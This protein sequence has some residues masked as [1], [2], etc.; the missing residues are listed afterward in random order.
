MIIP[1]GSIVRA[2]WRALLEAKR[3]VPML[4]VSSSLVVA[5]HHFGGGQGTVVL[6]TVMCL[7]FGLVAPVSWRVLFP[8]GLDLGHGGVRLGLYAAVGAAF[9]LAFCGVIPRLLHLPESLLTQASSQVVSLAL[10]LVGGWGLGHDIDR[11]ARLAQAE[12][13]AAELALAAERAELLALR[14][15]LDPHFLFN[16]L[17]A[18]A[19]WCR[20]DGVVAEKAVLQLSGMLRTLLEGARAAR[21]PLERELELA[22]TVCELHRLRD[23]ERLRYTVVGA[24]HAAGIEVPPLL[25]LPLVDN[26]WKHG[27]GAG[28]AGALRLEVTPAGGGC[29]LELRNPGPYAGPRTGGHGLQMVA[30]RLALAYGEAAAFSVAQAGDETVATVTLPA[31]GGEAS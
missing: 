24:E 20:E 31:A 23:P 13:R 3:L 15:N 4:L 7:A 18:I 5:Q 22:R 14:A 28:F 1:T 10:F 30:R 16:T 27:V 2:T 11:D 21:W 6:A 26:A 17:N 25:L 19:E 9:V 29:R 8:N 12:A